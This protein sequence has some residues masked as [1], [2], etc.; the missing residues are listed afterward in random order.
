MLSLT[1][2]W[3]RDIAV[4]EGFTN[5]SK[6]VVWQKLAPTQEQRG[7]LE[8]VPSDQKK[9]KLEERESHL[10][11]R[12]ISSTDIS[13]LNRV[14]EILAKIGESEIEPIAISVTFQKVGCKMD[15]EP[16]K[17][18]VIDP[19]NPINSPLLP[20]SL[21]GTK[22]SSNDIEVLVQG[23]YCLPKH[24]EHFQQLLAIC[25]GMFAKNVVD[26]TNRQTWRTAKRRYVGWL[27]VNGQAGPEEQ[28]R[29]Q[30]AQRQPGAHVGEYKNAD[31][32]WQGAVQA[33]LRRH[34]YA[35]K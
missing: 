29:F 7:F 26:F 11:Y 21:R 34:Q 5:P 10:H 27:N 8:F 31:K 23:P 32:I 28:Q 16:E 14:G 25:D 18:L 30:D 2:Y 20:F 6:W 35:S 17:I 9:K 22:R 4:P 1:I 12:W 33:E 15:W 13:S 24:Y 19:S 3:P